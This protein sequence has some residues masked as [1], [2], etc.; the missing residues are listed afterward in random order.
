[1]TSISG[2]VSGKSDIT[3][4]VNSGVYL[5]ATSNSN[6]G[7]SLLGGGTGDTITLVN[8]GFILG[9][10]GE[11]F[12]APTQTAPT[13]GGTA[14]S[15]AFNTTVN[16]TN[17]SAYIAGGGGGGGGGDAGGG[18][19]AGGGNGG[20]GYYGSGGLGRRYRCIRLS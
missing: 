19:G 8:N 13:A 18:G 5:Y 17:A 11:G 15:L 14:L 4:T 2:Y 20:S 16:N 9:Q 10:G 1:M 3:I 12:K 6:A 7:L